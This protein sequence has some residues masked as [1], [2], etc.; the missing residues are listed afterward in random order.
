MISDSLTYLPSV[1][2]NSD[3]CHTF[4]TFVQTNSLVPIPRKVLKRLWHTTNGFSQLWNRQIETED[5]DYERQLATAFLRNHDNLNAAAELVLTWHEKHQTEPED[6]SFI[7][8]MKQA[9]ADTKDNREAFHRMNGQNTK[10]HQDTLRKRRMA[11]AKKHPATNK[12]KTRILEALT[13]QGGTP[14]DL[15]ERLGLDRKAIVM[16]LLRLAKAGVIQKQTGAYYTL[17][18]QDVVS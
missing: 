5:F 14:A 7:E 11:Y 17:A 8:A 6:Q 2:S 3:T 12:T 10:R 4:I 13:V 16:Q 18:T 15:A 1:K 9:D